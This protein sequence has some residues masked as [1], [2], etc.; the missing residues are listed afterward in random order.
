MPLK[1]EAALAVAPLKSQVRRSFS[2]E[3]KEWSVSTANTV[4]PLTKNVTI[5]RDSGLFICLQSYEFFIRLPN[6]RPFKMFLS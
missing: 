6:V 3:L 4:S 2:S 5:A 1:E